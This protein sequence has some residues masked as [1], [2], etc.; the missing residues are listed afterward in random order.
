MEK[1]D[2]CANGEMHDLY[3]AIKSVVQVEKKGKRKTLHS[4]EAVRERKETRTLISRPQNHYGDP[5][6]TI[7]RPLGAQTV[8]TWSD[9]SCLTKIRM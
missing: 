3:G 4:P 7:S 2:A 8:E 6:R 1:M 9:S 5:A